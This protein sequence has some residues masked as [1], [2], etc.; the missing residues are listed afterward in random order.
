MISQP[1]TVEKSG[2]LLSNLFGSES[3]TLFLA[4]SSFG[5]HCTDNAKPIMQSFSF[6]EKC[7]F[8]NSFGSAD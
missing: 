3:K 1:N 4:Q 6:E 7:I 5:A 2:V 8:G